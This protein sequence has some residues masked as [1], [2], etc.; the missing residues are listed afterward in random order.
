M[1]L[2]WRGAI[3]KAHGT[4]WSRRSL[5]KLILCGLSG[6]CV[7]L[8]KL[9]PLVLENVTKHSSANSNEFLKNLVAN[10][11]CGWRNGGCKIP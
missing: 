11:G 4:L 7:T 9:D 10:G 5:T 1:F 8:F 3:Q 6:R 2:N